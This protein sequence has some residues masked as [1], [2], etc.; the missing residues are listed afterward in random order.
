MSKYL[1]LAAFLVGCGGDGVSDSKK[2]S[3]L[4]PTEAK[5][6]CLELVD[7]YPERTI[8]CSGT[9]ITIGF[10]A[11]EC[12]DEQAAPATCTATV[13]DIRDCTD[14]IYSL[15]DAQFCMQETLPAACAPL[16]G[17]GC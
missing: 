11:A 2:L 16:E 15:T 10:T 9:M 17:E 8:D 5:D 1:C 3:D 14:A 4:T 13:G 7:D 6:V 12:N